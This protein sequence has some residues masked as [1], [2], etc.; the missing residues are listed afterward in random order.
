MVSGAIVLRRCPLPMHTTNKYDTEIPIFLL[1]LMATAHTSSLQSPFPGKYV[2]PYMDVTSYTSNPA[3]A[4][5]YYSQISL[6]AY[7][8]LAITSHIA[9]NIGPPTSFLA[10]NNPI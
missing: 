7:F 2:Q 6:I 9:Y 1:R 3:F 10:E 8:H 5:I 4:A